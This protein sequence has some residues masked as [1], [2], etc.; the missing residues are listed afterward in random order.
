MKAK[1]EVL[2]IG[3]INL[4]CVGELKGDSIEGSFVLGG[5]GYN[6]ACNLRYFG[7]PVDF[8]TYIGREEIRRKIE[9]G[10]KKL[11]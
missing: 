11:E 10:F 5:K 1:E 7:F 9:N 8:L 3:E 6:I 2:V 4:D